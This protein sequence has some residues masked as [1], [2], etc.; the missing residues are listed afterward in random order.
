MDAEGDC[1]AAP[2]QQGRQIF[3]SLPEE[4]DEGMVPVHG[5]VGFVIGPQME[6]DVEGLVGVLGCWD[7]SP[8]Y[9]VNASISLATESTNRSMLVISLI[10]A[11]GRCAEDAVRPMSVS[12][13]EP[14]L[15]REEL[16][17]LVVPSL[18]NPSPALKV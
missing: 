5:W 18:G 17:D 11:V 12:L 10:W 7:V 9:E 1:S 6:G 3:V 15:L 14:P 16:N 2:W 13:I 8:R 4:A